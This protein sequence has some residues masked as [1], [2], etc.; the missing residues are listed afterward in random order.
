MTEKRGEEGLHVFG[1]AEEY[2]EAL[3]V[4]MPAA[5]GACAAVHVRRAAGA[6]CLRGSSLFTSGAAV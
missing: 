2:R 5:C 6:G 4:C 1:R 3:S